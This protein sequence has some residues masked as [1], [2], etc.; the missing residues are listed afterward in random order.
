MLDYAIIFADLESIQMPD[1][2]KAPQ[3]IGIPVVFGSPH[4]LK[5]IS[6][7]VVKVGPALTYLSGSAHV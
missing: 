7:N 1:V 3:N 2:G 4:Q 5:Y 6:K